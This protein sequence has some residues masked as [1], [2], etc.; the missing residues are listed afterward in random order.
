MVSL[1]LLRMAEPVKRPMVLGGPIQRHMVRKSISPVIRTICSTSFTKTREVDPQQ[2]CPLK[3][4]QR[5]SWIN[6]VGIFLWE[7]LVLRTKV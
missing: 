5:L 4:R 2:V 3:D 1:D 6:P 7:R